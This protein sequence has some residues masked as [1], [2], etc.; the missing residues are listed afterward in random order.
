MTQ[1][2]FGVPMLA[3][4]LFVGCVG[5]GE[6]DKLQ[7]LYRQSE[8]QVV[9]L[10][11]QLEECRA[12]VAALQASGSSGPVYTQDPSTLNQLETL[13][14]ERSQLANRIQQLEATI[15]QLATTEPQ[16]PAE[17]DT[18]LTDLARRHSDIMT[19]DPS[20]GMVKLASDLTFGLGSTDV[21]DNA[22]QSL[23]QL[24]QILAGPAA[25]GFEARI[26]GHT[27]NVPIRKA[28]TKRDH[29]TNWHL[30]V[31]RAIA[32]KDA[33]QSAGVPAIRLGVAGYGE[34]RPVAPN[35]RK[36]NEAN[37]R[38]EIYIVPSTQTGVEVSPAPAANEVE[39]A[40]PAPAEPAEAPAPVEDY[41]K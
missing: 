24:A 8:E 15:R 33:M 38:V 9:E 19:Y 35:G 10:K 37:R 40:A 6:R 2:R 25:S 27:D 12:R 20:L 29:P 39:A 4:L 31:H 5:Q 30:S 18:A 32:V 26:V 34:F 23:G 16:L 3:V 14:A 7:T 28:S 22:K 41:F 21:S 13:K 17:L 1:L 11:A 36:G